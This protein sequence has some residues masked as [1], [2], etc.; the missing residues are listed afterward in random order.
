MVDQKIYKIIQQTDIHEN[1]L[2]NM[3]FFNITVQKYQKKNEAK[4]TKEFI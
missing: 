2:Y 4:A 3:Y 1:H